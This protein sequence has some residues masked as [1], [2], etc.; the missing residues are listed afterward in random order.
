MFICKYL[1]YIKYFNRCTLFFTV[2]FTKFTEN[3][4]NNTLFLRGIPHRFQLN[5]EETHCFQMK[6]RLN[7]NCKNASIIKL[8]VLRLQQKYCKF[9][10]VSQEAVICDSNFWCIFTADKL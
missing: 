5:L 3:L 4:G 9:H 6:I 10:S 1:V 2:I 8:F 7:F